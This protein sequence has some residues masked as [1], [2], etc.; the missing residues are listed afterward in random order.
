MKTPEEIKKLM[1]YCYQSNACSEC[2]YN[3][4]DFPECV[5]RIYRDATECITHQEIRIAELEARSLNT[6]R[7]AEI[8]TRCKDCKRWGAGYPC[9][10]DKIKCCQLAGYM[11][12]GN[13]YCIYAEKKNE[14]DGAI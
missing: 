8:V 10:T 14:G 6:L 4:K 1:D 3:K 12:G 7:D 5:R 9:E 13:G 11:I 2:S